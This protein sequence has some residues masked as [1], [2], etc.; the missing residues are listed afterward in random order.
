MSKPHL[1]LDNA[2]YPDQIATMQASLDNNESPFLPEN[3][4]KYHHLPIIK[5]GQYWYITANQWPYEHTAWHYLIISNQYWTKLED[6][7]PAAAAEALEL[8]QWLK[9]EID[10][11]GG[12]LSL[13]FGDS[14]YSGA[15]IDHLHWQFIV[16][17]IH[18]PD[19]DRVHVTIGKKP[20]K[21]RHR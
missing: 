8:A 13:R 12:A 10:C 7:T 1:D 17:D 21:I 11:P 16:P 20:D 4:A 2:R 5:Q 19:Y 6:I 18:A 9:Q 15:T 3:L 14:N